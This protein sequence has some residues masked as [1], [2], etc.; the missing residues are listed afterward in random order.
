[1]AITV[2]ADERVVDLTWVRRVTPPRPVVRA[3]IP[4][5][6]T[7]GEVV[8]VAGV[9]VE[10]PVVGATGD[11]VWVEAAM[12]GVWVTVGVTA[13]VSES[14]P[15]VTEKALAVVDD[16]LEGSDAGT[17]VPVW[18]EVHPRPWQTPEVELRVEL[19]V[20]AGRPFTLLVVVLAWAAAVVVVD[21]SVVVVGLVVVV[22]GSVVVGL[23]VVSV[24]VVVVVPVAPAATFVVEP[25][26]VVPVV[27]VV[28]VVLVG[29]V[30]VGVVLVGA[31]VV[32]A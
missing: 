20:T 23:V 5:S 31:G 19:P 27:V 29:V 12:I 22:D 28:G 18:P 7:V 4:F 13:G 9:L 16:A 26:G 6:A 1:V 2:P 3:G 21:G 25:V 11:S 10:V 17:T 32:A 15:L 30:L 8:P 24:V 14:D